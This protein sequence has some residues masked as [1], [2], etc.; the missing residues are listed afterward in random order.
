[1]PALDLSLRRRQF[2]QLPLAASHKLARDRPKKDGTRTGI[3]HFPV[4]DILSSYYSY[5]PTPCLV[6]LMTST[7]GPS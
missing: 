4:I 6:R 3:R 1:M 2:H 7:H 5:T